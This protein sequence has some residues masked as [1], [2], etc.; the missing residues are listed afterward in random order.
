MSTVLVTGANR[1]LGLEFARQYAADGWQ[2]VACCRK[3]DDASA[4]RKIKG[5]VK[6]EALDV[7]NDASVAKL[8]GRLKGQAIDLLINNAG[9]YGPRSGT[10]TDAWLEV[11][12]VNSIAPFRVAEALAGNVARSQKKQI[13]NITSIMGSIG[14]TESGG[15]YV[16]RSSKAALNMVMKGLSAELS[17]K[18]ITI[19]VCHPG[20][21]QTDM[22][23]KGA[24]LEIA[25]SIGSLRKLIAKLKPADSGK[26]FNYDGKPLPW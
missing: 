25:D 20:W 11:F 6:I 3:P 4:L 16:Y 8:A 23:G 1:G 15:S 22:G 2:V 19:V 14:S 13:V 24:P 5:E 9:I 18:G 12:R 17:D 26:Y 10:D 21:V 7:A